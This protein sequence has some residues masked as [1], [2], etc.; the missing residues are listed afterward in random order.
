MLQ[1]SPLV[2]VVV[3]N[4]N[5]CQDTLE[6][7]RS[8]Y[9]SDYPNFR[10]LL[11]DNGSIDGTVEAAG[12]EFPDIEILK[13][14]S[15]LGYAE[16]NN[17][18]LR[19]ANEHGAD[20]FFVLNNDTVIEPST[21]TKLMNVAKQLTE[22]CILGPIIF[23]YSSPQKV[24]VGISNW[25]S[26]AA[27]FETIRDFD[28]ET[29]RVIHTAFA[30]GCA[31]FFSKE[32]LQRCGFFDERFFLFWED[33]DWCIRAARKGCRSCIVT[34]AR[35]RHKESRSFLRTTRKTYHYYLFR[36]KLLWME[37]NLSGREWRKGMLRNLYHLILPLISSAS[38]FEED[39]WILFRGRLL[40]A[41]HYSI[42]R[43][44]A[45]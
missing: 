30:S 15:N 16:G 13:N 42:R 1:E 34:A 41:W 7:L 5:G 45:L 21:I 11:V 10:G 2:Y 38:S 33:T 3:L 35:I 32:V 22:P 44:G 8:L 36:N 6:C 26:A 24:A 28:Y 43:F 18:G 19:Y 29:S 9:N 4:W 40:G 20:F 27:R 39:R 12:R 23:Q 37:K 31:L 14:E 25:N 17:V